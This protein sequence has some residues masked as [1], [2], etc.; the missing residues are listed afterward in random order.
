MGRECV[1]VRERERVCVCVCV[2]V[3]CVVCVCLSVC[4]CLSYTHLLRVRGADPQGREDVYICR[5]VGLRQTRE[6]GH[7]AL[8]VRGRT[9]QEDVHVLRSDGK[10]AHALL[11]HS[12]HIL[13][14]QP[15]APQQ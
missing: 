1:C 11:S 13:R 6:V 12:L 9:L 8:G 10:I 14:Q 3:C 5:C 2:C 7:E 15:F 4:L